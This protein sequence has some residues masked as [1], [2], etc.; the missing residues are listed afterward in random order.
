MQE[1]TAFGIHPQESLISIRTGSFPASHGLCLETQNTNG[2]ENG[3]SIKLG[4]VATHT[5]SRTTCISA[6]GLFP[7]VPSLLVVRHNAESCSVQFAHVS[8]RFR[9]DICVPFLAV[10]VK[11]F[12]SPCLCEGQGFVAV[13][14]SQ[15]TYGG[16][17][18]VLRTLTAWAVIAA[19]G[20]LLR[21]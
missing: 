16:C 4:I 20:T 2:R 7:L 3:N 9:L 10:V 14:Y 5:N 1:N 11:A 21:I 18:N 8:I 19:Q 17:H 12:H 6:A 15:L 13:L